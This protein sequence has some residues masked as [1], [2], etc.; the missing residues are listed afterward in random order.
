[1]SFFRTCDPDADFTR[2][3]MELERQRARRPLCSHCG[4]RIQDEE[5]YLINGDFI[6]EKCM[7]REFKVQVDDFTEM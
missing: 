7:E 2:W 5:A 6:C 3:D 1:M 4:V